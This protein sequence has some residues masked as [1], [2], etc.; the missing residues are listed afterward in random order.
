[1]QKRADYNRK[2]HEKRKNE[3]PNYIQKHYSRA[4]ERMNSDPASLAARRY[5]KQMSAAKNERGIPWDLD[6]EKTIKRI[7]ETK[8]CNLSG[9]SLVFKIGHPDV[10]S[11]DRKNS[12]LGYTPRN[13]QITSAQIN[14]SKGEMTDKE[15]VA[16]CRQ[17]AEYHDSLPKMRR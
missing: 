7:T 14:K 13:I 5:S 4:V 6:K 1:M 2:Y 17:V 3:D 12:K 10:P 9:R 15:F 8:I 11:I 16:M